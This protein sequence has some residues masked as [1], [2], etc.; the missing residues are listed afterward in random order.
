MSAVGSHASLD[1][2]FSFFF[3]TDAGS[4]M[5]SGCIFI[6]EAFHCCVFLYSGVTY[7]HFWDR[8]INHKGINDP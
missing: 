2:R 5:R 1:L 8:I 6:Y 4:V 7:N 3:S